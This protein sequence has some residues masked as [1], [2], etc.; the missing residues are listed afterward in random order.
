MNVAVGGN[1]FFPDNLQYDTP[2][3]WTNN[4]PHPMR[5]FWEKKDVW[6][7]TWDGDNIALLIDYVEII[8]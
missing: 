3:P 8:Q 7:K 1:R 2:K 4:S 6:L 5:D